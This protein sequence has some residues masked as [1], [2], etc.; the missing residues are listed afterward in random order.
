MKLTKRQKHV[1]I[2]MVWG[3]IGVYFAFGVTLAGMYF[4][5][6]PDSGLAGKAIAED[7]GY[8][9]KASLMIGGVGAVTGLIIG[10]P[11]M[12]Y[13]PVKQVRLDT[14]R[15]S[16]IDYLRDLDDET[17]E[18]VALYEWAG[19]LGWSGVESSVRHQPEK[20]PFAA[21]L[22]ANE[23]DFNEAKAKG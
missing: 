11:S 17:R 4:G 18:M 2:F 10:L 12:P 3:I 8:Q 20:Y 15:G 9:I 23:D 7:L 22:L 16:V 5:D 6:G 19:R 13:T 14:L 1:L 21:K